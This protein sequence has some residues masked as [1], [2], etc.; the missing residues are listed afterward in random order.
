MSIG[1]RLARLERKTDAADCNRTPG[2]P[3]SQLKWWRPQDRPDP[4]FKVFGSGGEVRWS[5]FHSEHADPDRVPNA[6][7]SFIAFVNGLIDYFGEEEVRRAINALF[8]ESNDET[9]A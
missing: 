2:W 9:S 5:H 7:E 4:H 8:E 1:S 6:H 3:Y